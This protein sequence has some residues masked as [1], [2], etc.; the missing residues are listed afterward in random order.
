ML[1]GSTPPDSQIFSYPTAYAPNLD[2]FRLLEDTMSRSQIAYMHWVRVSRGLTF[3]VV[4]S[5]ATMLLTLPLW[6][7]LTYG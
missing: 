3:Q 6:W 4:K 5:A 1:L 7:I 2:D